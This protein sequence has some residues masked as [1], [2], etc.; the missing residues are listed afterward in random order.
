[1]NLDGGLDRTL[2]L[3]RDEVGQSASDK[4]IV[5]ALST[6]TV[7]LIADAEN[8]GSHSAQTAFIT[9][10]ILMAR[11]GHK[12]FIS[13]PNLHIVGTQ[14]PLPPGPLVDGLV[15][16]GEDILPSVEFTVGLPSHQVDM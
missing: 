8:I 9:A 14:P 3:M 5:H 6:T 1:M 11:S 2:L 7:A 10:A 12:V 15:Q 4:A 13:A 16:V